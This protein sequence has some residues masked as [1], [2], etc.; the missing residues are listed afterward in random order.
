MT[1]SGLFIALL[2]GFSFSH[3]AA[4]KMYKWVDDQGVTHVGDTIPPEYANKDRAELN[5]SGRTV[6]TQDVLTPEERRAKAESDRIKRSESENALEQK[7]RDKALINTYSNV[8]E[9]E[10]KRGRDLQQVNARINSVGKQLQIV[11]DKMSGLNI[12]KENYAKS[13]R[14]LPISLQED[15]SETQER[16]DKL[17]QE[18]SKANSEKAAIDARYDADKVRFKEL[19]GK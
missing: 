10:L 17:H 3:P 12:E 5:K 7:R 15:L 8:E 1:K 9:I 16:L 14:K 19:T 11:T 18:L 13:G 6:K 2:V 4:A